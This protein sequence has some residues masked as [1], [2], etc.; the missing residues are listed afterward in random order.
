VGVEGMDCRILPRDGVGRPRGALRP[1]GGL[2][3]HLGGMAA[4]AD[5][6]R[7]SDA[8][9]DTLDQAISLGPINE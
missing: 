7:K 5:T 1:E 3:S 2:L 6:K 4:A 8:K 9:L